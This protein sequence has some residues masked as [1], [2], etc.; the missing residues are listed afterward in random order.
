MSKLLPAKRSTDAELL[1]E[2]AGRR[3]GEASSDA[4]VKIRAQHLRSELFA[5]DR[6]EL[7]R[8]ILVEFLKLCE[9]RLLLPQTTRQAQKE[10]VDSKTHRERL[11]AASHFI[12][13][14]LAS[15][16]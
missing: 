9:V 3:S 15:Q 14:V 1:L 12:Y 2:M 13:E 16:G 5:F 7:T 6:Q 11:K 4:L 10:M 8:C